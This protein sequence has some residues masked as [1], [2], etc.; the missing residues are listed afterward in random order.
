LLFACGGG[1][2]KKKTRKEKKEVGKNMDTFLS[3]SIIYNIPPGHEGFVFYTFGDGLDK[4]TVKGQGLHI[5]APWDKVFIY[6]IRIKEQVTSMEV[7]SNNGLTIKVDLSYRYQPIVGKGGY[8]ED[9]FGS[10]YHD[11][12]VAPTIRSVTRE[13]IGRY[14]L[15]E[16]YRLLKHGS[17]K[18]EGEI[19]ETAR[20][21]LNEKFVSLD[22]ILIRDIR[23]PVKLQEAIEKKT[24]QSIQ[25]FDKIKSH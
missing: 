12:V 8:I 20:A 1:D 21:I 2:E 17:K 24:Q 10:D 23:L 5:K 19:F 4:E 15:E 3:K 16:L 7:L 25:K 13:V 22:A 11:I 14:L 18:I 9:A 6:D